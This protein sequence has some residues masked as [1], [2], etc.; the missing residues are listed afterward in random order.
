TLKKIIE[1]QRITH[2]KISPA[3]L[4][5][6]IKIEHMPSCPKTLIVG[7]EQ[8]N[9]KLTEKMHDRYGKDWKIINE[10]GPTEATVGCI[11]YT[12]DPTHDLVGQ[13]VPIGRPI[14]NTR[15]Y[16]LDE[17][18]RSVHK[19]VIG[20]IYLSGDCLARGYADDQALTEEKFVTL[21]GGER[22][23]KTG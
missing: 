1:S 7:G 13:A 12:Y 2:I 4:Q 23:Y 9:L 6:A 14:M 21:D 15:V 5:L 18:R 11:T 8:L 22:A 16:L 3:H 20:E 19:G 10:Y 17:N